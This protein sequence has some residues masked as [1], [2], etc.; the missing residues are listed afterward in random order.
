MAVATRGTDP[1]PVA[2]FKAWAATVAE[3]TRQK[4]LA[5]DIQ[6]DAQEMVRRAERGIGLTIRHGQDEG[7]ITRTGQHVGNQHT[8]AVGRVPEENSSNLTA[9]A[10][11]LKR[12][13]EMTETYDLTDEVTDTQFEDGRGRMP[14]WTSGECRHPSCSL[15]SGG[16]SAECRGWVLPQPRAAE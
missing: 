14:G 1:T 4:G 6:H 10:D 7:E 12:G 9:P 5:A 3:M 15:S 11:F 16:G 13:K 8:G 2:E